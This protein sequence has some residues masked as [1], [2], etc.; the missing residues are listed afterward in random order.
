[1]AHGVIA[2]TLALL[3]LGYSQVNA[4]IFQQ[5]FKQLHQ[6]PPVPANQNRADEVQ[7][8]WIEQ[9]LDHFDDAETRTWQMRYMLN[10]V[11]FEAGGPL[12]IFLGGEWAISTGYVTGGHMYDMAK[13]HK[14]LLAY[15]E[16][17]YY[18]ESKPLPD[19]SNE[20]IKYLHVKQALADLAHFIRTK[21]ATYEGLSDSKV[22]IVGGSYSATMV[23][24][25][26]KTYP[27]LATGGWASSAPLFAKVNFVEYKEITGQSIALMGGSAC[28]NRIQNGIAE[29]ETM[30][31]TKRGG[32][33]KALLKLCEKFDVYSDLDVWT[34]FSEVSDIFAGVVQTHNAGQIEGVCQTILS[35]SSDLI[36][37]SKYLL[38]V[39]AQSGGNC[40]DL[41]YDAI[42]APLLESRYTGNI[43]RQWIYQTCNE[44]GWYQTSGSA[45]Q[46]FGTK[47]PVTYYT[48]MC[49]DVYGLQ[50]SNSFIADKVA[51]T[52]EYFGGLEPNV[53]NVYITHGQLDPWRA[54]GIQNETQATILPEYAHCK[55]FGS[56]SASDSSEMRASKE[57][58]AE[59]VRQWLN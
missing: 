35:E 18:G 55:D 13:E 10:D 36:G 38:T 53:E 5:T 41:S 32:E 59:L 15:T 4:N 48:T 39:F 22:I 40:Y 20:N 9:Q 54:M 47:F 29:L 19:L 58:V 7:T 8:L 6:E 28:Y 25:F 16:H 46:P 26:K 33:V 11:F 1:M 24:W 30:L 12:F 37:L 50:Y 3:T 27:D 51:E 34:L 14:G 31:A 49:A 43:M 44:Y 56:I 21:K 57:R 17:R 42:L 23:T 2:I 52:N 45:A